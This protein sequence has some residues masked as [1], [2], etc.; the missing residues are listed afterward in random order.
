MM[1]EITKLEEGVTYEVKPEAGFGDEAT[2]EVLGMDAETVTLEITTSTGRG[3][4]VLESYSTLKL[5]NEDAEIESYLNVCF[6][7]EED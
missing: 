1:Q 2:A 3:P 4:D 7:T 5:V 6:V